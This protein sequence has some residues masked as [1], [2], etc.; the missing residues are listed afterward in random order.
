MKFK[1]IE[2]CCPGCK[3]ELA[4]FGIE[5][6][7][8]LCQ[9]CGKGFPIILDIPD[10]RVF[11]DPYVDMEADRDKGIKIY[12]KFDDYDFEGLIDYYYRITPVV[13]DDQAQQFKQGLM[14]GEARANAFLK[15]FNNGMKFNNEVKRESLLEIGCGTAPLLVAASERYKRAIGIDI[16][17]RWLIVGKKR[18][19][20]TNLDI[21]L[22]CACSEAL[23]FPDSVFTDVVAESTIEH[24]VDQTKTFSECYRVILPGG[25]LLLSTPNKYSIG[26]DPHT[27]VIAGGYLPESWTASY[28]ERQGGIPP[29]RNLLTVRSL[30]A[31]L[32]QSKFVFKD[33]KIPN[34]SQEQIQHYEGA[35]KFLAQLY[36]MIIKL[37]LSKWIML[38]IGPL[39]LAIAR[40]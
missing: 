28:I 38:R 25:N 14:A 8:L 24:V 39:I 21:P 26:P 35:F 31:L 4:Y 7:L 13:T 16:A 17:F 40:K 10:L 37:P 3:G 6:S 19:Q 18:L 23:P 29:K 30:Q 2:I 1:G 33:L 34:L 9:E 22:I 36:R 11:S 32:R 5:D 20:E 12:A 27:G 15:S